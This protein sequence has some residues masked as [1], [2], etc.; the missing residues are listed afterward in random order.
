MKKHHLVKPSS[1]FERSAHIWGLRVQA[2]HWTQSRS[3]VSQTVIFHSRPPFLFPTQL[4]HNK[5]SWSIDSQHNKPTNKIGANA[6]I[7][8][9]PEM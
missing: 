3:S 9:N 2:K 4:Y 8:A 5:H 6:P 1:I 7:R